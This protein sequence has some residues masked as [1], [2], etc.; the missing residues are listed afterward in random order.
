VMSVFSMRDFSACAASPTEFFQREDAEGYVFGKEPGWHLYLKNFRP[1]S[2]M[3]DVVELPGM[4]SGKDIS[5]SLVMDPYGSGPFTLPKPEI[6]EN[7]ELD[8]TC[9]D[10]L[11]AMSEDL[12]RR[13]IDFIVVLLPQ[14][15]AWRDAYDPGGARDAAFRREV[16]QRLGG[17]DT[18]LIDAQQG[19]ELTNDQFTD[20]A[21]LQWRSVPLLMRYLISQ[22][23]KSELSLSQAGAGQIGGGPGHAL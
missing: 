23:D 22:I 18:V 15:P 9:L 19:L 6:R 16:S 1:V 5:A 3:R 17:T 20:H 4:R 8:P 2:F 10:H 13:G 14:M 12:S 11:S 7:F 21:H